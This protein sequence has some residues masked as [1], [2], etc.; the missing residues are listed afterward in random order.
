MSTLFV[1]YGQPGVGKTFIGHWLAK[2][3]AF[4]F[5]DA[6]IH[7]TNPMKQR[8]KA[9]YCFTQNMRNHFFKRVILHIESLSKQYSRI[10]VAQAFSQTCNRQQLQA[11]FPNAQFIC[12]QTDIDTQIE[13]L[14]H[15]NN[16]VNPAFLKTLRDIQA[17]P[18][19]GH[20]ILKNS[21]NAPPIA[22][23]LQIFL[24]QKYYKTYQG[25]SK[26]N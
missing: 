8:L 13:R 23:Q 4:Y 9:Q 17:P 19:K 12:I 24:P 18:N 22:S 21:S 6:D 16:F 7:L 10:A 14:K 1:L 25:I 2:H 26:T 5:Y 3:Y 11:A 20:F 15:R